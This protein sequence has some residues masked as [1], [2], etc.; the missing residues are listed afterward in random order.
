MA[1]GI[2]KVD[3]SG[4]ILELKREYYGQGWIFKDLDAFRDRH[5]PC[6]VP[7]ISDSVYTGQDF[8]DLCNG[9]ADI[10]EMIFCS[11][12]WQHPETYLDE[13]FREGE[14]DVC[15]SCGKIF[16]SYGVDKCPYCGAEYKSKSL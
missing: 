8:L 9:Q 1:I 5:S 3:E 4:E 14:L 7:E 12:D 11:V 16:E 10:A 6:Y 2:C 13:Q 15:D